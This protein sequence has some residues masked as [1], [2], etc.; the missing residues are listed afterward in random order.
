MKK[1]S[2]FGSL[3]SQVIILVQTL[4]MLSDS[5]FQRTNGGRSFG[6]TAFPR[7]HVYN[8]DALTTKD[9]LLQWGNNGYTACAYCRSLESRNHLYFE[10]AFTK[11]LWKEAM[12]CC[13]ISRLETGWEKFVE[14]FLKILKGKSLKA[15]LYKLA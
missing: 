4:D 2:P 10:C 13:P 8:D 14:W 6:N 12:R 11:R 5:N 3:P 7:Q 1:R 9:R 15:V